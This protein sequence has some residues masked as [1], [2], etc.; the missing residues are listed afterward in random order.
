MHA[1]LRSAGCV[2]ACRRVR[3]FACEAPAPL[4]LLC[5][6]GELAFFDK[7]AGMLVHPDARR[8]PLRAG[9]RRR[10]AESPLHHG[11]HG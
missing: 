4:Q 11:T 1:L 6:H 5:R 2:A 7:P 10:C 3:A 8:P 9:V